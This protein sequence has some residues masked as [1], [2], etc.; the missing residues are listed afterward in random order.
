[1]THEEIQ[2]RIVEL[3]T[4]RAHLVN[5][6]AQC[7]AA[8]ISDAAPS[9]LFEHEMAIAIWLKTLRRECAK[10]AGEIEAAIANLEFQAKITPLVEH[11]V[12]EN[13]TP[14][15]LSLKYYGTPHDWPKILAK[16]GL[17][18]TDL[19]VGDKLIIPQ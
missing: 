3:R 1:M 11:I 2:G 19:T 13:D 17:T 15:Y 12:E 16:N 8:D 9:G 7:D 18:T 4:L 14:Q 5:I 10:H 6:V